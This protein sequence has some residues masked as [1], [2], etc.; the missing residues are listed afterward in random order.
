[1]VVLNLILLWDGAK[2]IYKL[3]LYTIIF[4]YLSGFS[5]NAVYADDSMNPEPESI[6]EVSDVINITIELYSPLFDT[7]DISVQLCGI[8]FSQGIEISGIEDNRIILAP[9]T[10]SA[11][12]ADTYTLE[13]SGKG[14][15]SAS[16]A[17][18]IGRAHV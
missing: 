13:V 9:I 14:F 4:L 15:V 5:G 2:M 3:A 16:S 12:Q 17:I 18:K 1:M 11:L 10:V 7:N 6:A 8:E